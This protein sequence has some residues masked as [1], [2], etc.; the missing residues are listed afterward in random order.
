MEG[1]WEKS[2]TSRVSQSVTKRP[3]TRKMNLTHDVNLTSHSLCMKAVENK[4]G[5]QYWK[6]TVTLNKKAQELRKLVLKDFWLRH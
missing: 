1:V 2:Q 6:G 5:S 3:H 4:P